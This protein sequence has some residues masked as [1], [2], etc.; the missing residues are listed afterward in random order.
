[1][2]TDF[3]CEKRLKK[4]NPHY[5]ELVRNTVVLLSYTLEKY[6]TYF[7]SY[8][9]HTILHSLNVLD[10]C[11]RLLGPQAELLNEDELFV[12]MMSAY[13]H[14][15]GMG[16]SETDYEKLYDKVVTP[17]YR[18]KHPHDTTAETIRNFHQKFSRHFIYKY[19][20]LFEIP[21][22]AHTEAIAMVSEGHRKLDL[23]SEDAVPSVM[24]MPNGNPV[25]IPL[26]ASL[27]RLADEMDVAADRNI[28]FDDSVT[29]VAVFHLVHRSILHLHT[30]EDHFLLDCDCQDPT[31]LR[32]MMDE[33]AKLKE[34]L[35]LCADVVEKRTPFK[36]AQKD[37][38]VNLLPSSKKHIT[39]FE[40]EISEAD[41]LLKIQE[42]DAVT[43]VASRSLTRLASLLS[44]PVL[45]EKFCGVYILGGDLPR[46]NSNERFSFPKEEI[47]IIIKYAYNLTFFPVTLSELFPKDMSAEERLSLFENLPRIYLEHPDWFTFDLS[48]TSADSEGCL[49]H[50]GLGRVAHV[51]TGI[52]PQ[53]FTK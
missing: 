47:D 26:L 12:L 44:D 16:I 30:N 52:D 3:L 4:L 13:L 43:Y 7:P 38:K 37:V 34:T 23:Y 8:T 48:Y 18:A 15:S 28:S 53:V 50:V 10:F 14:D 32:V 45:R 42:A 27:I 17:E 25:H 19:A 31:L 24:I 1:M 6:K 2:T 51:C 20:S 39:I 40:N 36:I 33:V 41:A 9:D 11:N 5:H 22:E 49:E 21:S 35:L 29:E 46:E